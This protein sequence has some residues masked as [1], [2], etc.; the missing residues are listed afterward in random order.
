MARMESV[1]LVDD[2][3]GGAAD[4]TVSFS[5]E[6]TQW[7]IDLTAAH[8]TRL[9]EGLA[10]FVDAARRPSARPAPAAPARARATPRRQNSEIRQWAVAN[11]FPVSDR[12]RIPASVVEAYHRREAA[13]APATDTDRTPAPAPRPAAPA[14]P[15]PVDLGG[16]FRDAT[17]G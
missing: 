11:G 14:T 17:V 16:L 5:L 15:G 7:E 9:R 10:P 4:E 13:G 2:L 1:Q 12:G 8:A 3:D 6:G